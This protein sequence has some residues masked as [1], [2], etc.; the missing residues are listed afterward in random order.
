M[1]LDKTKFRPMNVL[2]PPD[3][4]DKAMLLADRLSPAHPLSMSAKVL[5]L[6]SAGLK[7]NGFD[8]EAA[9]AGPKEDQ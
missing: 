7:A 1:P 9:V 3:L 8:P 2:F 5:L 6:V 4:F